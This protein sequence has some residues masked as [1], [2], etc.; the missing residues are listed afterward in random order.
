[1]SRLFSF[2]IMWGLQL[3]LRL[4]GLAASLP[5]ELSHWP[6]VI[7][8]SQDGLELTTHLKMTLNSQCAG[9]IGGLHTQLV[10][11]KGF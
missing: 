5:A 3:D 2:S 4:S 11:S 8:S 6:H 9:T 10:F 1:M 7:S